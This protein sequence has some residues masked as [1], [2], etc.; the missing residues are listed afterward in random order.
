MKAIDLGALGLD[1][2][3]L[4][5]QLGRLLAGELAELLGAAAEDLHDFGV[6]IAKDGVAS[7][8]RGDKL[9]TKELKGQVKALLELQRIRVESIDWDLVEFAIALVFKAAMTALG[10]ASPTRRTP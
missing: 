9:W 6:A 8:L 3:T 10:A 7:I 2:A 5:L 1:R 4:E